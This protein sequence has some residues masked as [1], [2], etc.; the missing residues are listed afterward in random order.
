MMLTGTEFLRRFFFH[1]L[2]KSFVP[3]RHF[4]LLANRFLV[5]RFKLCRQ[6]LTSDFLPR[7]PPQCPVR[8]PR[9]GIAPTV[10]R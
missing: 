4:G 8:T 9:S 5:P 1:V 6:L 7:N 3:I 2:P 10:A